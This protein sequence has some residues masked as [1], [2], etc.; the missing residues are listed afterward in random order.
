MDIER[1]TGPMHGPNKPQLNK[2]GTQGTFSQVLDEVTQKKESAQVATA[3]TVGMDKPGL[4]ANHPFLSGQE[5]ALKHAAD[6]LDLMEDYAAALGDPNKTLS[7]I[8]PLVVEMERESEILGPGSAH[9]HDLTALLD[10]I[11][12]TA[13]VEAFKFRRGDYVE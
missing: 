3:R 1:I 10:Q 12:V 4:V 7:A 9:D 11:T 6:V 8:E 5:Q 2:N 13:R